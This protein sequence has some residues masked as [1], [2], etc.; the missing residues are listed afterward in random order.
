MA[1]FDMQEN[2]KHIL[3]PYTILQNNEN[4]LYI[5]IVRMRELNTWDF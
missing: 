5:Y 4:V 2:K 3:V 1:V